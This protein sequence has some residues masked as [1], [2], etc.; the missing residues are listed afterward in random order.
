MAGKWSKTAVVILCWNGRKFLGEFLPSL[1]QFQSADSDIVVADNASTDDSLSFLRENF[2]GV[3]I[4][5]L[6]KNYGF[7][8][9][10]NQAIKKIDS[11]YIVLINQD[12]AVTNNWLSPLLSL[13]E[14]DGKIGA[15]HPRI[16]S[17]LQPGHFEYAGA[18]GGWID[19]Y[20]YTFCRG[21]VFD[22]IE[23]DNNQYAQT[24]E[25]FWASGAC[26]LVRNKVY[27]ELGGLDGDFFAHMEEIDFCWRLKN[28]GYKVMY[29][30]DATV[31]HLGGGSLPHGNPF[32]TYLNFRNNLTMIAKNLPEKKFRFLLL[33]MLLD[34]LAAVR[35]L[36]TLH[37][38]DFLAIQKA[39]L[40]FLTHR[41][42]INSKR[43]TSSAPFLQMKGVYN[44]SIVWD[45][46]LKGKKTFTAIV[47]GKQ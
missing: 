16:H 42:K 23:K 46:F 36:L 5:A 37:F 8:E 32:K 4:I 44:G 25:V 47:R 24:A 28:A 45:Y 33:R 7:A 10:Y 14:S 1:I 31:Y 2:P 35:S 40:Y 9:G 41:K 13:I 18:A 20:G 26:M 30:S 17:H 3:K 15:V 27:A 34:Q 6:E 39:H 22:S 43:T 11:E 29:C 21:R 12:V 19:K 38:K